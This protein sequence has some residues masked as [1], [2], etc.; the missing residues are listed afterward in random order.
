M[1]H[2]TPRTTT[3]SR[4]PSGSSGGAYRKR[5]EGG[6]ALR[7][8]MLPMSAFAK[9]QI[10]R[11]RSSGCE[12]AVKVRV[13]V[14]EKRRVKTYRRRA[15]KFMCRSSSSGPHCGTRGR[16]RCPSWFHFVRTYAHK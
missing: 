5:V 16:I 10:W 6:H 7:E 8:T 15:K 14:S 9:L 4:Y 2:Q 13:H 12:R 11:R 3:R 1:G